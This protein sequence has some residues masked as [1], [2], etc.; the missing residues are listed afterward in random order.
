SLTFTSGPLAKPLEIL[1]RPAVTLTLAADQPLA[2]E[3]VRL[4]D[5]APA[6]ASA[7][8]TWGML[9]LTHRDS[10]AQP[11]PLVPGERYTVTIPLNVI[12]YK[13]P[14]GHRWRVALSPTYWRHA[15]PS[16][17]PVTLSLLSW[18]HSYLHLPV[19]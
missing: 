14:A 16:P 13:L 12:G 5:V 3:A 10:H 6:G 17:R 18:T 9:N 19:R 1:S 2:L 15:W 4:C 7:L 8:V 11:T